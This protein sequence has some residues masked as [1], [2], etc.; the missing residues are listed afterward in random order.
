[1]PFIPLTDGCRVAITYENTSG[2]QAVNV[3]WFADLEGGPTNA[4]IEQLVDIVR[5][6][7]VSDWADVAVADWSAVKIEGRGWNSVEDVYDV[8]NAS[9]PGTLTGAAMPS[10]VTIAVS[11]RTGLTGRSRRGR[12][13]HVGIGE[14]NI[15]GDLIS[16]AYQTNIE[17]AYA[18]L[19]T[20]ASAADFSW[21]VASFVTGGAPRAIGSAATIQE[22]L[23]VDRIVDS[24][25]KRKPKA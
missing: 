20:A 18:N 10:E 2:N 19:I 13:Y 22:V 16:E 14:T 11:L 4:R 24:Q 23:I 1:M 8:D 9:T 12:V 17:T 25:R 3:L 5:A 7:L 15:I 6:W 21:V